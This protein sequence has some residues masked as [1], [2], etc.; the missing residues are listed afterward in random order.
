M[1]A[2][3][4]Q[5]AVNLTAKN[6]IQILAATYYYLSILMQ[7]SSCIHHVYRLTFSAVFYEIIYI[8]YDWLKNYILDYETYLIE[9][10]IN[11]TY[12]IL[13][14]TKRVCYKSSLSSKK[15]YFK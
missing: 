5:K 7:S 13:T 14:L 2:V 15:A 10:Y 11:I 1:V 6:V 3:K 9:Q 8:L 12:S 4:I